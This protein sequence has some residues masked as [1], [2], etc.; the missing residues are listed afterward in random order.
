MT[1]R[2]ESSSSE[3]EVETKVMTMAV[4]LENI[5]NVLYTEWQEYMN[6]VV[7]AATQRN[8]LTIEVMLLSVVEL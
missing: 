7:N 2:T 6:G 8:S 4:V 5:S 3:E 1:T